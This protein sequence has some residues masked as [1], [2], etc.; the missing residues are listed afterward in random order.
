MQTEHCD[1][2]SLPWVSQPH[3]SAHPPQ[4]EYNGKQWLEKNSDPVNGT[5][6]S[7][8]EQSANPLVAMIWNP[9]ARWCFALAR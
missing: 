7:L 9:G 1:L 3:A 4:V 6:A 8:F 2:P 5:V